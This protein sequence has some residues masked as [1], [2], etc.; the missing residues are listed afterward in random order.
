ME[1]ERHICWPADDAGA[2]MPTWEARDPKNRATRREFRK[3]RDPAVIKA[4]ERRQYGAGVVCLFKS[5]RLSD[6]FLFTPILQPG[7][8]RWGNVGST[9]MN[10][11]NLV[12]NLHIPL[13]RFVLVEILIASRLKVG[14]C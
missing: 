1:R 8:A 3:K 7:K 4:C 6:D 5:M 12:E 11:R 13:A 2:G 10:D 9:E 14:T